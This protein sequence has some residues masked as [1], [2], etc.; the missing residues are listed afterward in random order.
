MTVF[1]HSGKP[2]PA[3]ISKGPGRMARAAQP[4]A[5]K[6]GTLEKVN[7]DDQSNTQPHNDFRHCHTDF[8]N[9]LGLAVHFQSKVVALPVVAELD[10]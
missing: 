6:K 9:R 3:G 4:L 1:L 10:G 7:H 5:I 2:K 8:G